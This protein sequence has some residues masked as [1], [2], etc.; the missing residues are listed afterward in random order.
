MIIIDLFTF[1]LNKNQVGVLNH[2]KHN[3]IK[4][5]SMLLMNNAKTAS[6]VSLKRATDPKEIRLP[7]KRKMILQLSAKELMYCFYNSIGGCGL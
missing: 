5:W 3:T 2:I 6:Y 1:F 4:K 7:V